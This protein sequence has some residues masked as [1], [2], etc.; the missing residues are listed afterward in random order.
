[1][2]KYLIHYFFNQK[3]LI[4]PFVVLGIILLTIIG[5]SLPK[6]SEIIVSKLIQRNTDVVFHHFAD[7][8]QFAKWN[9]WSKKSDHNKQLIQDEK[10]SVGH[11]YEWQG[12]HKMTSGS[13]E[14]T[15]IEVNQRIEFLMNIGFVKSAIARIDFE[16]KEN[17]TLVLCKIYIQ[18]GKNPISKLTY[19]RN[20]R[21]I[22]KGFEFGLNNL[23][24][25]LE[26]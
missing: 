10:M 14:I 16:T 11:R 7:F 17:G 15:H 26:K 3:M 5:I 25:Q 18:Y 22:K 20:K 19:L 9:Y 13:I 21:S 2:L 4:F 12:N 8:E 24:E 1:M 6:Q 23:K